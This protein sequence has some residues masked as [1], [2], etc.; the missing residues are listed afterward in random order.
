MRAPSPA[1]GHVGVGLGQPGKKRRL[2]LRRLLAEELL[3]QLQ[4]AR[5]VGD[6]LHGLDPRDVVEEPAA[7]R[8]HELRVALH[9]HQ[10]Q[11]AHALGV[12]QRARLLRGKKAVHRLRAAVEHD[13]NVSVAR[14]PYILE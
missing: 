13:L 2:K 6:D 3:R 4:Y 9:L 5:G 11:S 12:R 1:L 14:G 8:V 10:L 7:A